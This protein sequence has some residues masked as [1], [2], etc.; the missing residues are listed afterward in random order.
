ML[1]ISVAVALLLIFS[2]AAG[3]SLR[4][5]VYP[6][7]TPEGDD[8]PVNITNSFIFRGITRQ[9]TVPVEN[10]ILTGAVNARKEA[11]IFKKSEITDTLKKY[12]AAFI[13]DPAQDGMYSEIS[14]ALREIKAA[15]NLSDSEY[16]D[17]MSAFVQSVPYR[18][19]ATD[20]GAGFPAE[21]LAYG[22]DCDSKSSLLIGM[23]AREGY[24]VSMLMFPK[25]RHTAVGVAFTGDLEYMNSGY[26]YI[27]TTTISPAGFTP[28]IV[29]DA[30]RFLVI[31]YGNGD[32]SYS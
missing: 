13:F 19:N 31:P 17:L 26:I 24:N 11:Q 6:S 30:E 16:V 22:G 2:S 25:V 14:S 23:L 20:T 5:N 12:Y 32:K 7:I 9:V 10:D 27:E 21:T 3:I 4:D 29:K 28:D 1:I 18:G 15:E 8:T